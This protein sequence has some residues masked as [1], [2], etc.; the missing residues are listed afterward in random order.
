MLLYR[1][2]VTTHITCE[3]RQQANNKNNF[4]SIVTSDIS[5]AFVVTGLKVNRDSHCKLTYLC[6]HASWLPYYDSVTTTSSSFVKLSGNE[7]ALFRHTMKSSCLIQSMRLVILWSDIGCRN[8]TCKGIT[9]LIAGIVR[10]EKSV[11]NEMILEIPDEITSFIAG[12]H[13]DSA[14]RMHTYSSYS[15]SVSLKV[16]IIVVFLR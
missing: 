11:S 16:C 12:S 8:D 7:A 3:Q 2:Q 1:Q 4:T 5:A 6:S 14:I 9:L 13:Q 10:I 15:T